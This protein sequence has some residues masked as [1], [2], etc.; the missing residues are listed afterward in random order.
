[1]FSIGRIPRCFEAFFDALRSLF[2][3]PQWGHFFPAVLAMIVLPLP[4]K[5]VHLSRARR[6]G[7]HRTKLGDFFSGS[8]WEPARILMHA[9]T[10][11]LF[12][13]MEPSE[14]E[15]LEVI[16]DDTKIAKR[17]KE[18]EGVGK[19]F[20]SSKKVYA[21]GHT[22]LLTALRFRGI[23]F[24]W[25]WSVYLKKE[26]CQLRKDDPEPPRFRTLTELAAEAIL[27]IPAPA[28][29][30]AVRVLFDSFYLCREVVKAVREKG[31]KFISVAKANRSFTVGGTKK[32]IASYGERVLRRAALK[33]PIPGA[34]KRRFARI[35]V[36]RGWMNGIGEV[37]VV[38]SRRQGE[39]NFIAIVTD[40]LSLSAEEIVAGYASRWA[41]EI[42]F[43]DLKQ[44][45]GLGH[46]QARTLRSV[47]THLHLAALAHV[48]LTHHALLSLGAKAKQPHVVL[49][50]P[51]VQELRDRIRR[52]LW[53]DALDQLYKKAKKPSLR[54]AIEELRMAA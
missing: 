36:R 6:Q 4:R 51:T 11:L 2:R 8:D 3:K 44:H 54:R 47:V 21:V 53:N 5:I 7:P 49:Q 18:M 25:R 26:F 41:V 24:P 1:L 30:F 48:L 50:I 13:R 10:G 35:A 12:G 38:F 28:A 14:G 45:L 42:A 32:R 16:L 31:Y 46:Y 22:I 33:M 34:R 29:F 37:Q 20:D 52:I 23:L 9:V 19:L 40:D 27:A 39:R 15:R 43:K 17:A